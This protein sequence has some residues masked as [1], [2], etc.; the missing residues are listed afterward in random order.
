MKKVFLFA[1]GLLTLSFGASAQNANG[2]KPKKTSTVT[3]A[4]KPASESTEAATI[5]S[6]DVDPQGNK[7]GTPEFEEARKAERMSAEE[8]K[9]STVQ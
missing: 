1:F 2:A 4:E 7:K 9:K 5:L 6:A 8:K 3:P